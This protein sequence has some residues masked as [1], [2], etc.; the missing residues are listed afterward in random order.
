MHN[1][2]SGWAQIKAIQLFITFWLYDEFKVLNSTW[3]ESWKFK[4]LVIA[5][6]I[7]HEFHPTPA[8]P[9]RMPLFS[10]FK[11]RLF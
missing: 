2:D 10:P 9:P 8:L 1:G 6:L 3:I 11:I 5:G 4:I 7:Y